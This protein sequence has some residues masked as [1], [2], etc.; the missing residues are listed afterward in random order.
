MAKA[1]SKV[2][3]VVVI[4]LY[5]ASNKPEKAEEWRAKLPQSH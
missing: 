1:K 3:M 5:E 2:C 4:D